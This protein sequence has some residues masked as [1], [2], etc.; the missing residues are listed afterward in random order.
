MITRYLF[1]IQECSVEEITEE[2][3]PPSKGSKDKKS[4]GPDSK[5]PS[6]VFKITSRIPYKTVL[7]GKVSC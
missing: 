5:K 3:D 4:N 2:E 1:I 6:L 7:K